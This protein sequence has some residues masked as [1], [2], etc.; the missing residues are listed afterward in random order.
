[1]R[2]RSNGILAVVAMLGVCLGVGTL[3][4]RASAQPL[5]DAVLRAATIG[6]AETKA[7]E[8]H[9]ATHLKDLTSGE[10]EKIR[11]A[12]NALVNPLLEDGV[13][14]P[15]RLE[16]SKQ[17]AAKKLGD[18]CKDKNEAVAINALRLAGEVAENET[19]GFVESGFTDTRQAVRYAAVFAAGRVFEQMMPES[20]AVAATSTRLELLVTSVAKVLNK[21]KEDALIVDAASRALL[22]AARINRPRY[23]AVAKVASV[24][25]SKGLAVRVAK[26]GA[27]DKVIIDAGHR[28]AE[29]FAGVLAGVG[30]TQVD[31]DARTQAAV[32]GGELAA[33]V[34]R[35][36]SD[37][38]IP[39]VLKGDEKEEEAKKR[40]ARKL[41]G[42]ILATAENTVL[43]ALK[44]S[45][46]TVQGARLVP[47]FEAGDRS[48]DANVVVQVND[49]LVKSILA[50]P[51]FDLSG[52]RF[53]T[54]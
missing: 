36:I 12:K 11:R 2:A 40:E 15:F 6:A 50:K 47:A 4:P 52:D 45:G 20:R 32:L 28:A 48:G 31:K 54:K 7:I 26:A 22:A 9:L 18:L 43:S 5:A 16:Y 17:L 37:G 23:E 3:T 29:Q 14:V 13:T 30:G 41:F 8:D 51:P 1:M 53:K 19:I 39:Q 46:A 38:T 27:T 25:V 35:R 33:W 21:D 42:N 49:W 10:A 44:A 24:E 34:A